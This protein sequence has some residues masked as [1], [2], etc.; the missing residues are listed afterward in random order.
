MCKCLKDLETC[1]QIYVILS[2]LARL[3]LGALIAGIT[4]FKNEVLILSIFSLLN[5]IALLI[6]WIGFFLYI[7][8][9]W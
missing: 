3:I 8:W 7:I 5:S 1:L 9:S 4:G 2:F 6:A